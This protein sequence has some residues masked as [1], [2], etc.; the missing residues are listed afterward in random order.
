MGDP[1]CGGDCAFVKTITEISA[2][3]IGILFAVGVNNLLPRTK[4]F[5][6]IKRGMVLL[7]MDDVFFSDQAIEIER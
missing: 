1:L 4:C 6:S 3:I 5:D 7:A 2:R